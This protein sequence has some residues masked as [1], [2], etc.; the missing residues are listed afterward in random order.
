MNGEYLRPKS[1]L[2]YQKEKKNS[3]EPKPDGYGTN[4]S[5][6]IEHLDAS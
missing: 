6:Q 5:R 1:M 4:D 2:I 3:I